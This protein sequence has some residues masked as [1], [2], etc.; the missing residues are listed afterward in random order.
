MQRYL[1]ATTHTSDGEVP[2]MVTTTNWSEVERLARASEAGGGIVG[3][4]AIAPDG[5]TFAYNGEHQFP[6]ASTIK[7]PIMVAVF[8]QIDADQRALDDPY[9]LRAEAKT[10]GS[11]V[12]LH[13]HEPLG[14]TLADLLYLMISISDN[15][16]TNILIDM[17]T[18]EGVSETIRSLGMIGSR[19]GRKMLGRRARADEQE[20]LATPLDFTQ[21]MRA[22]LD[23]SAASAESCAA[24][25]EMLT[26]QQNGRRIGRF[27]PEGEGVR[28]GSK[29]GSIP[30]IVND[31]GFVTTPAGT[32]VIAVFTEGLADPHTGER[33]IGEITHA[34]MQATGLLGGD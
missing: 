27:V 4:A 7:I 30:G 1:H 16:A 14:L 22:I 15:T 23:G 21:A 28:W 17:A 12:L 8:R 3:V 31:A 13:L 25:A 2:V 9:T 19:L 24:M 29:T 18:F 20:N 26:K 34:A 10:P 11:G 6:A 5:S 32:L 33:V